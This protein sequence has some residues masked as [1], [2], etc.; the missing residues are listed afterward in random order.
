M[1]KALTSTEWTYYDMPVFVAG[2]TYIPNAHLRPGNQRAGFIQT[3]LETIVG[4]P[5]PNHPTWTVD[6]PGAEFVPIEPHHTIVWGIHRAHRRSPGYSPFIQLPGEQKPVTSRITLSLMI[7]MSGTK[8]ILTHAYPGEKM[9]PP[10]WMRKE[11]KAESLRF[12]QTHGY[13]GSS[14][15]MAPGTITK[16][17]PD[18]G[19]QGR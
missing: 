4:W 16:D 18:W 17:P 2:D 14:R 3:A 9:L 7:V 1:T 6:V 12:W 8:V 11:A 13:V 10:A 15:N 19:S 5:D